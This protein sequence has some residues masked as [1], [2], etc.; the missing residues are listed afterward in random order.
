MSV[1]DNDKQNNRQA[2]DRALMGLFQKL[3]NRFIVWVTV[4]VMILLIFLRLSAPSITLSYA[5]LFCSILDS[6][7]SLR[8]LAFLLLSKSRNLVFGYILY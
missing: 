5:N 2:K 3:I 8:V 4:L 6:S 7:I 1:T